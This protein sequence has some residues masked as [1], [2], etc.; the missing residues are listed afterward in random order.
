MF[1]FLDSRTLVLLAAIQVIL[2]EVVNCQNEDKEEAGSCVQDGQRYS[3]KDVW[4]PEPCQICVCDTGTVLCD[5]ILCEEMRDCPR[6]EIPFG[7]CCPICPTD[8]P[9]ASGQPG[10]KGQK[11]E[12]GDIKN[13]VGPKGPPGAQGPSGEPGPRG[14]RGD[15]GERGA[16]G[17]RGPPGLPGKPGED[18]EAG[19][20]GKSG[21]RGLPGPQ[22][23]RGF[24]GTPGLPGVKGHRG[25]PG[26]DGSKGEA[27]APGAKGEAGS[28]GEN[29]SPGPMLQFSDGIEGVHTSTMASA[30]SVQCWV[31]VAF[32]VKEDVLAHLVLLDLLALLVDQG[33]QELQGQRV[34]LVPLA[35]VALRVP[36]ALEVNLDPLV[37]RDLQDLQATLEVTGSLVPKD[38]PEVLALLV[39]L[40]SL[41]H[42][43]HLG[44]KV[45]QD[46]WAPKV[47]RE[48]PELQASKVN[49][50]PR[51]N[52]A[53]GD[54]KEP[55]GQPAKKGREEDVVNQ[56][57]QDQLDHLER[58]VLPEN[59]A[60][61]AL[62]D[63]K[64]PLEILEGLEN[65]ACLAPGSNMLSQFCGIHNSQ[66]FQI[67]F[68]VHKSPFLNDLDSENLYRFKFVDL[69]HFQCQVVSLVALGMLVLKAKLAHLVFRVKMDGLAHL[70]LKVLVVS[71]VSWVSQA[72]KVL[73]VKA[74][75]LARKGY[76]VLLDYEVFLAKMAYSVVVVVSDDDDDICRGLLEREVN[77]VPLDHL[78]SKDFQDPQALQVKVEKQVTKVFLEKLVLLVLLVPEVNVASQENAD[79]QV[80][81][82]WVV[83]EGFPEPLVLMD[84]RVQLALLGLLEPK[85]PQACRECLVREELEVFLDQRETGVMLVRKAQKVLLAKMAAEVNQ[86]L[87]AQVELLVLG[88]P[89]VSVEK[90]DPLA[91]LGLLV[92]LVLMASLVLKASKVD[93]ARK[94]ML[95]PLV[96][97]GHLVLLVHSFWHAVDQDMLTWAD[98]PCF[99]VQVQIY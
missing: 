79:L 72:P 91:P 73:M 37:L 5:D 89:L 64:V 22:G 42:V 27:G 85:A 95:G 19:K 92:P 60:P 55:L 99:K 61:L 75:K 30:N 13:V 82:V 88:V 1:S 70:V 23:A 11:G 83:L 12:P 90:P 9:T 26:L 2:L 77:K 46:L 3:D 45:Q 38:Q 58:G 34:K 68:Y 97:K 62:G 81:K 36:K 49:K 41:A 7:E 14:E 43:G 87:L 47:R 17:P 15:K 80:P 4:K 51:V 94:E 53:L 44:H 33:F 56:E 93:L 66:S 16:M 54:H 31:L 71:L 50:A 98:G 39:L 18:G 25:Y 63:S 59:V 57:L 78:D 35:L 6:P 40:V 32:Q 76:L 69:P 28:S 96:H 24:P 86:V 52:L 84:P 67:T 29:G 8:Q 21:E 48:S 20:P 10:P 74:V 65:L